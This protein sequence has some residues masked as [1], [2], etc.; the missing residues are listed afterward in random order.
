M[1]QF[2]TIKSIIVLFMIMM[3][4]N[5]LYADW[6]SDFFDGMKQ[7]SQLRGGSTIQTQ[8]STTF[9]GGGW[10]W[11][12][13]NATLTP[14]SVK[15]PSINAGCSGISIDFGA[16]S[17]IDEESLIAFLEA[18]LQ[19]APGYAFELAMQ[20]LCPSC[21]DI[22]NTLNQIANTLNGAQLDACGTL[23][24][25]GSMIDKAI[26]QSTDGAL[27]TGSSNTFTQS[28]DKYINEPLQTLNKVLDKA[29]SCIT[30]KT[31]CPITFFKGQDSLQ[32]QIIRDIF[33]NNSRLYSVMK[34]MFKLEDGTQIAAF[35][36]SLV[37][38]V[39]IV[40][41]DG[42]NGVENQKGNQA[43][44]DGNKEVV[45]ITPRMGYDSYREFLTELTYG[46]KDM[47]SNMQ[48]AVIDTTFV[49]YQ[50]NKTNGVFGQDVN[51]EIT[52]SIPTLHAISK[53]YLILIQEAF[54]NRDQGVD[55][56]TLNFIA[57]FKTP[58]YKI[59][60][61][62]SVSPAALQQ[63]ITAFEQ[64]AAAQMMYELI[65]S[66]TNGVH[67]ATGT[68]KQ[69][70]I[71]AGLLTD[72]LDED[73]KFILEAYSRLQGEAYKL[74]V[75][76]YDRFN[77]QMQDTNYLQDL[78]KMQRAMMARHPVVGQKSFVPGLGM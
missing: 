54:L 21:L 33:N 10:T 72:T 29:F 38:D 12:G 43:K 25:A 23:K 58:V 61:L 4:P 20:I 57:S 44:G 22:M 59:L 55:Q 70:I 37:G 13:N 14:F 69:N 3:M 2:I 26:F 60:N 27:G 45:F 65:S 32:E 51:S 5:M 6:A 46:S 68:I 48:E 47:P 56:D 19:A 39:V 31:G 66:V 40:S 34:E 24:A 52:K 16:F 30:G 35:F 76:A 77:K 28:M 41:S 9:S 8:G 73:I 7:N 63:F 18:L 1:K 62:Y 50:Y 15:A 67:A 78:Q 36:S 49:T 11:Q 64:L 53:V 17:M 74:Y 75:E 42:Y 71:T